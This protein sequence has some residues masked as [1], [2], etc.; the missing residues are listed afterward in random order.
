[1]RNPR[2]CHLRLAAE[3]REERC[4]G[5]VCPFW[6]PGGAVVPGGCIIE[7]L[8]TDVRGGYVAAYLLELRERLEH[9]GGLR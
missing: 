8:G 7:R 2:Y 5:D 9:E 3:G 6:E 4:T 1:M